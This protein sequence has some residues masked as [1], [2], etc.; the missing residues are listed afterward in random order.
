MTAESRGRGVTGPGPGDIR[1]HLDPGTG[2]PRPRAHRSPATA[3]ASDR[4]SSDRGHRSSIRRRSARPSIPVDVACASSS[5]R[6]RPRSERLLWSRDIR[7]AHAPR[8][9]TP[10]ARDPRARVSGMV[11]IGPA[12]EMTDTRAA[13]DRRR[14]PRPDY[15]LV[16]LDR[17][18]PE[19]ERHLAAMAEA[20]QLSGLADRIGMAPSSQ[21][22]QTKTL[23]YFFS[24]RNVHRRVPADRR[25]GDRPPDEYEC[26]FR[27]EHADAPPVDQ[28]DRP[29]RDRHRPLDRARRVHRPADPGRAGEIEAARVDRRTAAAHRDQLHAGQPA[30]PSSSRRRP[31]R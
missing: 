26:L 4:P 18:L 24:L 1:P 8:P 13:A 2:T 21:V 31:W 9:A 12:S 3:M 10:G 17:G 22:V 7:F 29:G 20:V 23:D 25:A 15:G 27:P 16:D 11:V 6:S 19:G 5:R 28:R 30:R 14:G